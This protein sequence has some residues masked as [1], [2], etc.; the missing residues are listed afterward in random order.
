VV[1]TARTAVPLDCAPTKRDTFKFVQ[2]LRVRVPAPKTNYEI[3]IGTGLIADAGEHLRA[4]L[5]PAAQHAA[6]ISNSR[7]FNL[8]G[9][10][11]VRALRSSGFDTRVWL[12]KEGEPHKSMRSYEHAVTFLSDEGLER[13]DVVVALGG[14]VVGDL[15]GFAAATYL[16]G[17]AFIQLP[18][19]LLAQIDASVGGKVGINIPAGKNMVGAFHQPRLVLIDTETLRTLPRRE[20]TSGWC[21]AVKQG[22]VGDRKLFER[23]VRLLKRGTEASAQRHVAESPDLAATIGAHCRFKAGI[24]AGDERE[25]TQ[26]ADA[27]SRKILNFGHTTA[28]ALE[29]V[30]RFRRFR[31]GEAVGYGMLVAGEISKSL[32]ML[33]ADALQSLRGGVRAC[34]PLPAANDIEIDHLI[35][36]MKND[37]KSLSGSLKWVLLEAI[38]KARIVDGREITPRLLRTVL[39]NGLRP[40]R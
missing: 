35:A 17:L 36:A 28:H 38:G 33:P 27:R 11:L 3:K 23:T 18:T 40:V 6:V 29:T 5:G 37:K 31:H 34:G 4:V 24:V 1:F 21:E 26:R 25:S 10:P 9:D 20:L 2:T 12:M 15:A 8:F 16:R 22:A 19:T 32:G 30:T 14:G 13:S 39:R 7:V